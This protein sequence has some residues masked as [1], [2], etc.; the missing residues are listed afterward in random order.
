MDVKKA[1]FNATPRRNLFMNFPKELGLPAGLVARHVKCVYG[2]RDAGALWEDVYRHCL[3]KM[4]FVSGV[5]SPCCFFHKSRD[6]A[7]VVHGDDFTC[8]GSDSNLDWYEG[9]L[10]QR[11]EI[12]IRG[13]LGKG[14]KGPNEIRILNRIVRIEGDALYYEADPRHVDLMAESLNIEAANSVCTPGIK[15]TDP[16]TEPKSKS[17]DVPEDTNHISDDAA[18][19]L[20]WSDAHNLPE[21]LCAITGDSGKEKRS[22]KINPNPINHVVPSFRP[23]ALFATRRGWRTAPPNAEKFTG[24]SKEIMDARRKDLCFIKHPEKAKQRRQDILR[25]ANAVL[26][27]DLVVCTLDELAHEDRIFAARTP[28]ANKSKYKKRDGARKVK[29]FERAKALEDGSLTPKS[30][31]A[32]RGISAR[33]NFLSQDRPDITYSTKELCR[34]FAVP[35]NAS[36][37]KLKRLGRYCAGRPRLVYKFAF[38]DAP[39]YIDALVDTDFAGCAVTR[40]STSGGATLIG[41]C[42]VKHWSKTQSTIALSSGE[43]ELGGIACG[44]AQSLGLQSI[45][46]DLGMS[47]KLR[48]HSDATAAIGIA[49][50]RGLG[51]IRHLA[52][53]DL[54]VQ[55]KIRNGQVELHKVLGT[56]NPADIFTKYVNQQLMNAALERLSLVF[57]DGRSAIAP[58]IMVKGI[59]TPRKAK[60]P[61][62]GEEDVS[63][64]IKAAPKRH[65][66]SMPKTTL[67]H[68][69]QPARR[70]STD[71]FLFV[72]GD[73]SQA[74][75]LL[76]PGSPCAVTA[77]KERY[78]QLCYVGTA[79]V[80]SSHCPADHPFHVPKALSRPSAKKGCRSIYPHEKLYARMVIVL[81]QLS[82]LMCTDD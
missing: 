59:K 51:K 42:W 28:P 11:F 69:R 15:S 19:C 67:P 56:E 31:T 53:A 77:R 26:E 58:Q 10:T 18:N 8:M 6:L 32:F 57:E 52:T 76:C 46:Q 60:A 1:Y 3:E 30:A 43:A 34:D 70:P 39:E 62:D 68:T 29:D 45:C 74:L 72:K 17:G 5:A 21:L 73:G 55:E 61:L 14:C 64:Q 71:D 35:N 20:D 33:G 75:P 49:K 12:K 22:V 47:L 40:R 24:M 41:S 37:G 66:L 2:A 44:M 63:A 78:Q 65:F 4:G 48:L 7:C 38:Q 9:Q 23:V 13:R 81:C 25:I 50:R 80:M 82:A 36:Y 79:S 54:W 16:D 27:G